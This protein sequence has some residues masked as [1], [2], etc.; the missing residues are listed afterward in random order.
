MEHDGT[1]L[2]D[3]IQERKR[4]FKELSPK[5]KAGYIFDYYKIPI[6]GGIL[7]AILI[8]FLLYHYI[9]ENQDTLVYGMY[10]NISA[11][12][13]TSQDVPADYMT[14]SN[15]STKD[16]RTYFEG[17]LFMGTDLGV[18]AE[19]DYST[20]MKL[21]TTIAAKQLDF[22]VCDDYVFENYEKVAGYADLS[23]LLPADLF[24]QM[25]SEGRII[26]GQGTEENA[27]R[28][29]EYAMAIDITDTDFA[30]QYHMQPLSGDTIYLTFVVNSTKPDECV[31]VLRYI[32]GQDYVASAAN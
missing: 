5:E 1:T 29:D 25:E 11:D 24:E 16:Y 10:V 32:F 6:I 14:Y 13:M 7:L 21:A 28:T 23:E 27:E 15:H 18:E 30:A 17:N 12:E 31:N 3:A 20:V 8:G 22:L 19:S 2:G 4:V 26:Y 9:F